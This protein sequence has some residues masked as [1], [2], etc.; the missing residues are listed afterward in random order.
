MPDAVRVGIL[1]PHDNPGANIAIKSIEEVAHALGV[2]ARNYYASTADHLHAIFTGLDRQTCD[3]LVVGPDHALAIN[4]SIIIAAAAAGKFPVICAL[5]E[6][7]RDGALL[8]LGPN[9]TELFR[10]IAY[11]VDAIFK[12][13]PPSELPIEE[14]SK[15]SLLINLKTA[16]SLGIT[17]PA[18]ILMRADELIE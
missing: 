13:T 16:K 6:Y 2:A 10:R 12:G 4:R 3:V 14:A 8:S 1:G 9:R 7:A 18:P 5:P 11:Y 17:I 15:A